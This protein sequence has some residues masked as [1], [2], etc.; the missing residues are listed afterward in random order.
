MLYQEGSDSPM[1]GNAFSILGRFIP[2]DGFVV[3]CNAR[4]SD[5][6]QGCDFVHDDF[7]GPTQSNSDDQIASIE[8]SQ[9][10]Y[11][12]IDVFGKL[13]EDGTGTDHDFA[14]ARVVR[15]TDQV[16]PAFSRTVRLE[17]Q[18]PKRPNGKATV[19]M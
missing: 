15:K 10:S 9:K 5:R 18:I 4:A 17:F 14:S 6:I 3:V 11:H 16:G 8:Q 12:N 19:T 1:L 7:N 2:D 13:G